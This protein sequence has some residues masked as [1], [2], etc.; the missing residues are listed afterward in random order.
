MKAAGIET[1]R[2]VKI[3]GVDYSKEIPF[4]MEIPKGPFEA[5]DEETPLISIEDM[6]LT[7]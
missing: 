3:K 6:N 1:Q 5:S 2:N 4:E 7:L